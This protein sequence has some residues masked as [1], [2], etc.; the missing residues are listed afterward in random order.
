[1]QAL[2]CFCTILACFDDNFRALA[3]IVD[4]IA[5]VVFCIVSSC[6]TAQV[7]VE[8]NYQATKPVEEAVKA[9]P[10]DGNNVYYNDAPH[11]GYVP[12]NSNY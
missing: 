6:M 2:D 7:A 8:L 10:V 12:P 1:M 9:Y 5:H 4:N 11:K 3:K